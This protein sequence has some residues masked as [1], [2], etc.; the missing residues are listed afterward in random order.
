MRSDTPLQEATG[1]ITEIVRRGQSSAKRLARTDVFLASIALGVMILIFFYDIIFLGRTLA[2]SSLLWGVMGTEPPFGYPDVGPAYNVYLLDPLASAVAESTTEKIAS[3]Y[4]GF[5]VP[6]WDAN[7]ALGRPL[8]ASLDPHA[9]DPLRAPIVI[10]PSPEM[11]DAFLL[12]RFFIAGFFTYL[13]AKRLGVTRVAAFGAAV[14]FAFSG[15]FMLYVNMPHPDFAMLIPMALFAFDLLF[16]GSGALAKALATAVVA[17]AALTGNP[18]G[19]FVVL[20]FGT[21]YYGALVV[22]EARRQRSALPLRRLVPLAVVGATGIGLAAFALLPFSELTG[23]LGYAG[24][25]IHRHTPGM[26]IGVQHDSLQ[27]LVSLFLP[28]F[29]GAPVSN[30]QGTGLSGLRNYVGVMVPLLAVVGFWNGRAMARGGWFFLVA[31]VVLLAKTY[32]VPLA[33]WVGA[34]P[35]FNVVDMSLY[36]APMVAFSLAILAGLGLDQISR[37]GWRLWHVALA[38]AI[39]ASLLGWLVWLNRDILGSIPADFLARHLGLAAALAVAA[40]VA[41]MALRRGLVP[42]N[43]A[44]LALVALVAGELFVFSIPVRGDFGIIARA[45]YGDDLRVLERPRRH[46]P[47]TEPP[48]VSFLKQDQSV[49]RVFGLDHLLYPNTSSVY[50]IDDIRSFTAT[51]VERYYRF[52]QRFLNP[53]VRSRYTGAYLPPLRSESEPTSYVANPMFDLLNVKYIIAR[54]GLT[55]LYEHSLIDTVLSDNPRAKGLGLKAFSIGGEEEIVLFQHPPSSL[56]YTFTPSAESRFLVFRLALDPAVWSPDDGDGVLFEASLVEGE[57]SETIFS[58]WVDP[59]NNPEDRRWVDGSVD[60]GPYL[61]QP[62]TLEL[63]TLPGESGASD[64]A[65]WGGLRLVDSPDKVVPSLSPGQYDLVYDEEVKIYRNNHAFPRAFVVH[66]AEVVSGVEEAIARMKEG[67][68]NP[69]QTAVI[70]GDLQPAR[71][72]ALTEGRAAGGSS[73][74]FT[75]HRDNEV[76]LRVETE[77]PGLLVL[78][79]TYYPG[80]QAYVD[81]EKTPIYPTDAALR[82]VYLEAGEHEVRFVYS[83]GTFKLGT[84]ISGLSL[85]ALAAFAAWDPV[86][87][88]WAR[89]RDRTGGGQAHG[90]YSG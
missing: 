71:L 81:G 9:V 17:L 57:T 85:L 55:E 34:L 37:G 35:V 14:A 45:V 42:A 56:S 5:N 12:A 11:W 61:G 47:F 64:W 90:G 39:L 66:Q 22:T 16:H 51:T 60:L 54:A 74:E 73:V 84:A 33:N 83:P 86:R 43:V 77:R 67:Q 31:S 4:H 89:L 19:T 2:T 8:L 7:M 29:D 10:S 44:S 50:N 72:A 58:R 78:S 87:R 15:F 28:Y 38:I 32:G 52:I 59:K 23:Q 46:D 75:E 18:E 69:A 21:A 76:K 80:W 63:S 25:S 24:L 79:D 70:E 49:H 41:A 3:L 13:F 36:F 88:Q 40:A 30:F 6:L 26:K 65:G 68:F 53:T 62:I 48:F 1:V 20:L 27:H 82:S